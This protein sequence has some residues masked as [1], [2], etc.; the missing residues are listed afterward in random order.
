MRAVLYTLFMAW[1][2]VS[3][4][5]IQSKEQFMAEF[6]EVRRLMTQGE[7]GTAREKLCT[8]LEAHR[9]KD[10]V[11]R[12]RV[13]IEDCVKTCAFWESYAKPKPDS[14]VSGKLL[15]YDRN[16]GSVKLKYA[17]GEM[18]DFEKEKGRGSSKKTGFCSRSSSKPSS[19][20]FQP[21]KP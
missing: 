17:P 5:S 10:Y 16:A 2:F 12:M 20:I 11:T 4:G 18:D 1:V 14:V 21:E 8:L 15:K 6:Q 19:G 13:E 9:E 3:T 7:W